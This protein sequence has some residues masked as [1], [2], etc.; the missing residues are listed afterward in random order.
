MSDRGDI[1]E[2]ADLQARVDRRVTEALEAEYKREREHPGRRPPRG[3]FARRL[4]F[5]SAG[6]VVLVAI[7]GA[8]VRA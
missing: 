5:A 2:A 8:V 7:V 1:D 6:L 3:P 4:V